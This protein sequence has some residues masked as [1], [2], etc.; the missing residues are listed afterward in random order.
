MM[1][2]A[3]PWT[4]LFVCL[5]T[6]PAF[7]QTASAVTAAGEA[8]HYEIDTG[9]SS[10]I[11]KVKRN[12][13]S[14][15]FGRF[16]KFSGTVEL[17]EHAG[18]VKG[19][20]NLSIAVDSLDT[21]IS[22]RDNKLKSDPDLFAVSAFPEVTFVSKQ[23]R[24][25]GRDRFTVDGDLSFRGISQPIRFVAQRLGATRD[26][27]GGGMAGFEAVIPFSRGRFGMTGMAGSISDEAEV[28]V[29][30]ACVLK[31][32]PAPEATTEAAK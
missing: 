32:P 22:A 10:L 2:I 29:S 18:K 24:K 23:I 14:H 28:T 30:L 11:F 17:L 25:A 4:I 19:Q 7:A 1:L 21:G 16:N 26:A 9:H 5:N 15:F 13:V 6:A 31:A 27:K 20:V 12:G 8:L 3:R